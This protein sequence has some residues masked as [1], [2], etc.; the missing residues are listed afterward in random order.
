MKII[1]YQDRTGK[2]HHGAEQPDG[3]VRRIEGDILGTHH[4]TADVG[5]VAKRLVPV[6]PLQIIGIGLNYRQHAAESNMKI[7]DSP[8]VFFKGLNT[9]LNPGEPILLPVKLASDEVDYECSHQ[10]PSVH[11]QGCFSTLERDCRALQDQIA[12]ASPD[13]SS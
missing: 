13:Q 7:P 5:V 9:L 10:I 6:V 11:A 8:V 2:I 3:V 1:R 12:A 4:V